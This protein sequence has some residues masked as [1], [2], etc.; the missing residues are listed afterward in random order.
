MT[1]YLVL[2]WM[3][4]HP[5]TISPKTTLNEAH[6]L[7]HERRIRR[8]PVV[9]NNKLVGIVTSGDLREAAPSI[10]TSLSVFE[11]TYLLDKVTVDKIMKRSVITVAH[12]SPIREAARIML[13]KKISGLP[14]VDGERLV[15]IITES[16]IFRMLVRDLNGKVEVAS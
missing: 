8:L 16:D 14:V 4:P 9:E 10:V 7:M 13:F 6:R 5:I 15:G 11:L 3:N 2:E 12:K 1:D